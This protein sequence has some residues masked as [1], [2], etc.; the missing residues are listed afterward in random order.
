[1]QTSKNENTAFEAFRALAV[2]MV[3][4]G[5]SRH[6]QKTFRQ[7]ILYIDLNQDINKL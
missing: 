4:V 7:I 6:Y 1:M 5:Y 2:S 3:L